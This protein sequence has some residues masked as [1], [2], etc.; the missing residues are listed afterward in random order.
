MVL[1]GQKKRDG[2]FPKKSR[3][4]YIKEESSQEAGQ[5]FELREKLEEVSLESAVANYS[6]EDLEVL[7]Q[8]KIAYRL[9]YLIPPAT[10]VDIGAGSVPRVQS[11]LPFTGRAWIR[12]EAAPGP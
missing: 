7:K 11:A 3:G 6:D 9:M 10:P 2:S 12:G 5:I 8:N 1:S 4:F